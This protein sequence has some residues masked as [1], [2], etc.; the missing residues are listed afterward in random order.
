MKCDY[1]NESNR[2]V[3]E[4]LQYYNFGFCTAYVH[5]CENCSKEEGQSVGLHNLESDEESMAFKAIRLTIKNLSYDS[6]FQNNKEGGV[7]FYGAV[8]HAFKSN[9]PL[10]KYLAA[11]GVRDAMEINKNRKTI[12]KFTHDIVSGMDARIKVVNKDPDNFLVL[13]NE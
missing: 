6:K 1:C 12:W 3:S 2:F 7:D 4:G 9:T 5:I 11:R 13:W 8:R 10:R